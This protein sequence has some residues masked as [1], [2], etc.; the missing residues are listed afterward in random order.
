MKSPVRILGVLIAISSLLHATPQPA[1]HVLAPLAAA[2][3]AGDSAA[4]AKLRA[5]GPPGLE[6]VFEAGQDG[7]TALR[8]N[9]SRLE[10][11]ESA[12]LRAALDGVARQ[13]DAFASGLYWFTD[14]E[15]AKAEAKKTGRPILSLR[16]LGN[17]DDE[18]SCANSR[19]FRTAL[20]ANRTV[21]AL[22]RRGYVLHWKSV[23]PVPVLTID[24][25]DGR[26]IKRTITGNSIHYILDADGH[27]LDALPGNYGPA[28]FIAA[29]IKIEK[30]TSGS[31]PPQINRWHVR[32]AISLCD[33]WLYDAVRAGVY[34]EKAAAALEE[35]NEA[36]KIM[37]ELRSKAFPENSGSLGTGVQTA[38]SKKFLSLNTDG[39]PPLEV[40]R[41]GEEVLSEMAFDEEWTEFEPGIPLGAAGESK[42]K[43][44][45]TALLASVPLVGRLFRTKSDSRIETVK[46]FPYPTEFD[47]PK[48][49]V[50]RPLMQKA[51][52]PT[53][54]QALDPASIGGASS[55][56]LA[57]H[58]NTQW[59]AK[60]A[61]RH[62]N[63]VHLD[64]T[65][66]RLMM[67]KLPETMFL[68][69]EIKSGRPAENSPFAR[70]LENFEAAIARDMVRNEYYFHT[71]IH[72]WLEEDKDGALA[73]DVEAL[74]KRVYAEL[75]LTPDYDEWLGL[76]PED[77]YTSLEKE[78][79]ACD[80]GAPPMRTTRVAPTPD[81]E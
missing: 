45:E 30:G 3:I 8:Q 32:Q 40:S 43:D 17:L 80:K 29:L 33:A 64:E 1:P 44:R 78:G 15:A 51:P 74:N 61:A 23:R 57:H 19:F 48:G 9:Q 38:E 77:T 16:L 72:Q 65:S 53:A 62:R 4:I 59:W 56:P 67:A 35:P 37:L 52:A 81:T 7:I 68:P 79:W 76:V 26:R 5:A 28:S 39:T 11:P 18:F 73:R 36:A 34:G 49:M 75:F 47:P 60:I 63:V 27:V 21:S 66:R 20:Y 12:N 31:G 14:L 25:G 13:R 69:N 6:A 46:P 10:A 22:L 55:A 71:L 50:E 24:M 70:M 41:F 54:E 42:P 58:M 2:A